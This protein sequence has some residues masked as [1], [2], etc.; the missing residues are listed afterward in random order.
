MVF[1]MQFLARR[2]IASVLLVIVI[3]AAVVLGLGKLIQVAYGNTPV[4]NALVAGCVAILGWF[5]SDWLKELSAHNV[6][7]LSYISQQVGSADVFVYV[8]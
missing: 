1:T 3:A 6:R 5:V 4:Q 2:R 7:R 8:A